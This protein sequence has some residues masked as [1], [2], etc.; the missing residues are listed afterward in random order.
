MPRRHAALPLVRTLA[1]DGARRVEQ[2][3]GAADARLLP[4]HER[5]HV[6]HRLDVWR[7]CVEGSSRDCGL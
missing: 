1:A 2:Q 3:V 5:V 7:A 4:V 6:A